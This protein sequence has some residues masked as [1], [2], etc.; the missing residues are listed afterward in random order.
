MNFAKPFVVLSFF[1][2][3]MF[4][5]LSIAATPPE[6]PSSGPGSDVYAHGSYTLSDYG[7]GDL[8]YWVYEPASPVPATAPV[9]LYL[10][11]W[12]ADNPV[13][14][15]EM[16]I[17]FARKGYIVVF[18]KYGDWF[19]ISSYEANA[20][21]A[22][23]NALTELQSGSHVSPDLDKVIFSGHSLGTQIASRMADTAASFSYPEPKA[24]ILHEPAGATQLQNDFAIDNNMNNVSSDTLLTIILR[25]DW[26]TD[27]GGYPVPVTIWHATE[28]LTDRNAFRVRNDTFGSP[29]LL[30]EHSSMQTSNVNFWENNKVDA[31]D[32]WGYWRPT[33]AAINYALYGTDSQYVLGGG[34][35][36]IDMGNWSDGTPVV[37]KEIVSDSTMDTMYNNL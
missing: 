3:M 31:I 32:T 9:L 12:S 5:A 28:H 24:L 26:S 35:D 18:P 13:Y 10:H 15:Q 29:D 37:K 7:S 30:S 16:L 27:P 11:G 14:Y 17:H 19:N 23:E 33:E 1:I 8:K 6:Q 4:P 20:K 2:A 22:F 21:T 36:V 34:A 25:D